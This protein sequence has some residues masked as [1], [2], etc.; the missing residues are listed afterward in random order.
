MANSDNAYGV[1]N[2]QTK[3]FYQGDVYDYE[4][5]GDTDRPEILR[6]KT[7]F[8][9]TDAAKSFYFTDDAITVFNETCTQLQWA[10]VNDDNGD[11]T[12]LKVTYAF[13]SKGGNIAAD[14]DWA[15]QFNSRMTTL[16]NIG[17]YHKSAGNPKLVTDS[18]DHLF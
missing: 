8:A 13:G 11:A 5:L 12:K 18:S 15:G 9:N 3:I 7:V 1:Y 2:K 10:L 17:E 16:L 4:V 14:S 6:A